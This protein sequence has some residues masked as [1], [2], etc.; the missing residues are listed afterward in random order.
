MKT[1]DKMLESNKLEFFNE[2]ELYMVKNKDTKL[3]KN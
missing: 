2:F 1:V 3:L